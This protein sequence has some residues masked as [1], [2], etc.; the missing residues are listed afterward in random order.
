MSKQDESEKP[1]ESAAVAP[2]VPPTRTSMFE[3]IHSA[4]YERQQTIKVLDDETGRHLISYVA[5][6]HTHINR[7]D[8]VFFAD[9]LERLPGRS[10]IDLLLHTPGGDMDTAEKMVSMVRAKSG[11]ATF[12]VIVPDFAKSAGTLIAIGADI[13][14][15]SDTS[16]LGPIDPQI[17]VVDKD[18]HRRSHAVQALLDA[19]E[20]YSKALKE[21][22]ADVAA[23]VM[24]NKLDPGTL[25]L[26]E[27]AM[28]RAR[29]LAEKHLNRGMLQSWKGPHSY[30]A[31]ADDLLNTKKWYLHSQVIGPNDA[32]TIGLRIETADLNWAR[33]WKLYC[34][35]RLAI[36]DGQK[37]FESHYVS[38]FAET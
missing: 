19:Y 11:D 17:T 36:T 30:T 15:M 10:Q 26:C 2:F 3:A 31:V 13:A 38:H 33:Y 20:S 24:L 9:L 12:R 14:L 4:R 27:A 23:Q 18:G 28:G 16:E 35:Q 22:P 29:Q 21:N 37:L 8:V 7:D 34:R 5:G 6:R 32:K 1:T 25:K